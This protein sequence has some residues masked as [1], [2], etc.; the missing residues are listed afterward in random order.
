MKCEMLHS[1]GTSTVYPFVL[2]NGGMIISCVVDLSVQ[3]PVIASNFGV[4]SG[5]GHHNPGSPPQ[6]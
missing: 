6:G 2:Y 1:F 5:Q 4:T 3:V